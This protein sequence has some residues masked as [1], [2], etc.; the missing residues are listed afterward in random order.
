MGSIAWQFISKCL[1]S[2][3]PKESWLKA[4]DFT[5]TDTNPYPTRQSKE[6]V[7]A[8]RDAIIA[9]EDRILEM[10]R[11]GKKLVNHGLT[12]SRFGNISVLTADG[13]LITCTGAMLDEIDESQVVLVDRDKRCAMD[14]IASCETPVHRAIYIKTDAKA[15]I[16]THSPYAVALSLIESIITPIDSEGATFLGSMPVVDGGFGSDALA[17]SVSDALIEHKACI[18]R[19][20]GV[21]AKGIDLRDAYITASMAEHSSKVRYLVVWGKRS[22]SP[23]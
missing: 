13:I 6:I 21:F 9:I 22:D 8:R 7:H 20:H 15:V 1:S 23:P 18:A 16:H 17:S 4:A 3:L 19:G 14:S 5:D 10:A 12:G 11:F 2:H